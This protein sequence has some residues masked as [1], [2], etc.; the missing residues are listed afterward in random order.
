MEKLKKLL[1]KKSTMDMVFYVCI[2]FLPLLQFAIFYIGVNARSLMF[3]FQKYDG[4]NY[5]SNGLNN[6]V[7]VW[8]NITTFSVWK[9][10]FVNSLI[11][12]VVSILIS[13]PLG[14]LFSV[15]IYKKRAGSQFFRIMLFLPT[16]FPPAVMTLMYSG[17]TDAV[18][19]TIVRMVNP[20]S[21]FVGILVEK[22]YVF[23]GL[24]F[25]SIW[26]GFGTN[27]LMYVGSMT[28]I[29]ES[30][31]EASELDGCKALEEFFYITLPYIWPTFTTFMIVG[32]GGIFTNQFNIYTFFGNK[33]EEAGVVTIGYIL[34]RD[35]EMASM[36]DYPILATYGVVFTLVVAPV[37]FLLKHFMGK[38]GF[39]AE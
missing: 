1:Q 28:A 26:M 23:D 33:G 13:T 17:I 12:Y 38:F 27:V 20:D 18:I 5:V 30:V 39:S 24:L 6:F 7:S 22:Q 29:P 8:K 10:G 34:F 19:P 15:Y 16:V 4:N 21:L 2:A 11:I 37:T 9:D 32:I 35:T 14:V 25:Y 36:Y 31:V 3:V